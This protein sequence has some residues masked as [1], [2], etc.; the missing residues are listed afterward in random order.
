VRTG[1]LLAELDPYDYQL[2]VQQAE[3]AL[4][5]ARAQARNANSTYDRARTLY[6]NR[7]AS[8]QDLDA[9]R[10]AYESA[11]A[12][13]IASEKQ[14]EQANLHL[15]Y[16]KIFAAQNGAI[17]EVGV[18]AN[19]NVQAGFPI[20]LMTSG[21]QLEVRVSIPEILISQIEEEKK[22]A[23]EF[24]AIRGRKL[25]GTVTEV[26]IKSTTMTTTFPVTIELD[27]ANP[28]IRAGMAA[29]VAF[30]FESKDDRVRFVLPS[31][32][33]GEDRDGR[34]VFLVKQLPE[35]EG[36]GTVHRKTVVV[37]ELTTE[38]IEVF[39]GLD[40]EDLVVTAGISY[41]VDGQ[42]VKLQ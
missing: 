2:S 39:E 22:V 38:G 16:T 12:A 3:A 7:S 40:D 36:Y 25:Q 1:Q 26:G 34:F 8:K 20:L 14:L 27:Q 17:A 9:A 24:D 29:T 4:S 21:S 10:L 13:V 11:N 35:E 28:D 23:V 31:E 32:A 37:G 19:E 15:S 30:R 41:I 6:E 42:K 5:Q 33:I 18:E